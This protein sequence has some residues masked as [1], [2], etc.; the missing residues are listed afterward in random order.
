[1]SGLFQ[2]DTDT[3]GLHIRN[4]YEEGELPKKSTTEYFSVVQK[5]GK[6]ETFK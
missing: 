1:M 5:E 6:R 4:I 3:V 2:K